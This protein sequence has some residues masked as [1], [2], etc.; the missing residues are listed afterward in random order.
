[1]DYNGA[2]G[3]GSDMRIR[4]LRNEK[5]END[6]QVLLRIFGI[7]SVLCCGICG[8]LLFSILT[9]KLLGNFQVLHDKYFS[10]T[11]FAVFFE[12]LY[13]FV[14]VGL[15]FLIVLLF[16]R[17]FSDDAPSIRFGRAYKRTDAV[18]LIIAGIGVCFLG[19]L[20]DSILM[21]WLR[22]LGMD[23]Y[24]YRSAISSSDAPKSTVEFIFTCIRTAV[25]PAL[26]EEFALRGVVLGALRKFGDGFAV[27][28]SALLFG[29]MHGNFT[30]VPFALIAGVALGF[31]YVVTGS[32]WS[33]VILHFCNN[34]ISV[35]Y[36]AVSASAGASSVAVSILITYGLIFLGAIAFAV[37]LFRNKNGLRLPPS[38][39][40]A[41]RGKTLAF[42]LSPTF[43]IGVGSLLKKMADDIVK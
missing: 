25:L 4:R 10:A 38:P 30:Q 36:N 42:M 39:Y 13:A 12:M 35:I 28:I 31:V 20:V 43:I 7:S 9:N 15:P 19:N 27:G 8:Y 24:S 3:N 2:A 34:L 29:L 33:S 18:L 21:N 11:L 26:L 22:Q 14:S 32:I 41:T 1:M 16:L 5:K 37:Y 23:F 40:R 17:F 6:R